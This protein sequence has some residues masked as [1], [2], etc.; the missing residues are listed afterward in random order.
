MY[1]VL[2]HKIVPYTGRDG[3][4]CTCKRWQLLLRNKAVKTFATKASALRQLRDWVPL[5]A[6]IKILRA[7]GTLQRIDHA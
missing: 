5:K 6:D 1:Y 3:E 7:N 4:R 2:A